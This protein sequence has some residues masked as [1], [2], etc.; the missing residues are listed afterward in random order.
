MIHEASTQ[1][2]DA[3][4]ENHFTH[5]AK[6]TQEPRRLSC[7]AY[8]FAENSQRATMAKTRKWKILTDEQRITTG[9]PNQEPLAQIHRRHNQNNGKH[10]LDAKIDFSIKIN[11]ST[12]DSRRSPSFL[13]HFLLE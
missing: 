8:N 5:E 7:R 13:P 3:R 4:L 10:N 11:K 1:A 9:V 2:T 6:K 12:I